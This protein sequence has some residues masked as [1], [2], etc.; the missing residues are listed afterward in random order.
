MSLGFIHRKRTLSDTYYGDFALALLGERG[1]VPLP[2]AIPGLRVGVP[3]SIRYPSETGGAAPDELNSRSKEL[4]R[5]PKSCPFHVQHVYEL[6][7][8]SEELQKERCT[9]LCVSEA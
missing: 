9:V 8:G 6:K 7:I 5:A 2:G 4:Q 1:G 3:K